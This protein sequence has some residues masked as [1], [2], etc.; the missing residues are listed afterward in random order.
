M[1]NSPKITRFLIGLL[2]GL[3][4]GPIGWAQES[5]TTIDPNSNNERPF[6]NATETEYWL[7]NMIAYHNLTN[8]EIGWATGL[9]SEEIDRLRK[10]LASTGKLKAEFSRER[11]TMLPYPGGRHPRIGFLEGAL[12]PQRETK[13]SVFLPWDPSSYVVVDLPE[14]IWSNLGLTYLAHTHIPTVFDQQNQELRQ[15]EWDRSIPGELFLRRVLPNQIEFTSLARVQADHIRMQMTLKNGTAEKLSDLRVQNCVMLKGAKGFAQQSND[16]KR[17]IG[18]YVVCHDPTRKNWIITAWKPVHR[19]WA[20][21]P[22]PCLH[23]DP[24]FPDCQPGE[25]EYLQG[26]LSFYQGTD[27]D[28]EIER[29][30]QTGWWKS[31]MERSAEDACSPGD[32]SSK[33]E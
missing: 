12:R 14:A 8:E 2:L 32:D 11:L 30:D 1:K 18:P 5:D 27:I 19:A 15:L 26:W 24:K 10:Q 21:P 20:N 4:S 16:N 33:K 29:I 22:C 25:T 28:G 17:F 13:I 7:V 6:G 3:A 31:R 9:K 23:S